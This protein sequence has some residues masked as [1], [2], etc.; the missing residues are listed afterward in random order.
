MVFLERADHM[1]RAI[2]DGV[3]YGNAAASVQKITAT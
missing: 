1:D 3:N 2:R